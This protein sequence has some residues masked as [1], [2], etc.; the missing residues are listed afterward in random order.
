MVGIPGAELGIPP[1]GITN[2]ESFNS[3]LAFVYNRSGN[4]WNRHNQELTIGGENNLFNRSTNQGNQYGHGVAM[5]PDGTRL[6]IGAPFRCHPNNN[7]R[8]NDGHIIIYEYS[9]SWNNIDTILGRNGGRDELGRKNTFEFSSDGTRLAVGIPKYGGNDNGRLNLYQIENSRRITNLQSWNGN[10]TGDR[11]GTAVDISH[12]GIMAAGISEL[13]DTTNRRNDVGGV[14]I[15][16][17]LSNP[18][19]PPTLMFFSED[20]SLSE[21]TPI[22]T[23]IDSLYI[24]DPDP[25]DNTFV[26]T[27]SG[28]GSEDFIAENQQLRGQPNTRF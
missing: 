18:S 19:T 11:L 27:L 3:G 23:F 20:I 8:N 12:E 16:Y 4:T 6:A 2:P 17:E 26:L 21:D 14:R 24:T 28:E 1:T 9:G 10:S 22:G 7:V 5:S 15:I 13:D 25:F